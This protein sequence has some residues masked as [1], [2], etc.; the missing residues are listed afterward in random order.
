M[1][2][3]IISRVVNVVKVLAKAMND[4]SSL[5]IKPGFAFLMALALI[6][7]SFAGTSYA[8]PVTGGNGTGSGAG[9]GTMANTNTFVSMNYYTEVALVEYD[10]AGAGNTNLTVDLYISEVGFENNNWTLSTD[11]I[12]EQDNTTWNT[13]YSEFNLSVST[14]IVEETWYN[15]DATVYN[16]TD[17]EVGY[18]YMQICM[19]NGSVC[20][21]IDEAEEMFDEIDADG[22]GAINGTELINHENLMRSEDNQSPMNSTEE[23]ELLAEMAQYDIGW[24]STESNDTEDANDSMLEFNEFMSYYYDN[25]SIGDVEY[26]LTSDGFL[27]IEILY[28]GNYYGYAI[29]EIYSAGSLPGD[30]WTMVFNSSQ[31]SLYFF[32]IDLEGN[33]LTESVYYVYIH[34]YSDDGT[35]LSTTMGPIVNYDYD[36]M[37]FDMYDS[38]MSGN[39][40][41][42]E[43]IESLDNM[44]QEDG[45]PPM[46]NSSKDRFTNLFLTED[47]NGD[48]E[49]D[50][51]EFLSFMESLNNE[52]NYTE[53]E[54][55]MMMTDSDQ[56]GNITLSELLDSRISEDE[57]DVDRMTTF[58]TN[59]FN[60][61]DE[62]SNEMLNF[63][64]FE[65]FYVNLDNLMGDYCY[66]V[67]AGDA[68]TA[69]GTFE[70]EESGNQTDLMLGD[71]APSNG[72]FCEWTEMSSDALI[73]MLDTDGDGYLSLS[74]VSA[75]MSNENETADD[76]M[77]LG[78][79]FESADSD[80][81]GLL[82]NLEFGEFMMQ[83]HEEYFPTDAQIFGM[84]DTDGDGNLSLSEVSAEFSNENETAYDEMRLGWIFESADSDGSG[85]LDNLEFGEFMMQLH[86]EYFPTAVQIMEL[87]DANG[88]GSVSLTET[89]AFINEGSENDDDILSAVEEEYLGVLFTIHDTDGDGLMSASE[90]PDFYHS[91]FEK[92]DHDN[93]GDHEI[94][95][96]CYDVV[97]HVTIDTLDNQMDCEYA[98][99]MWTE[100]MD[101]NDGEHQNNETD[102]NETDS[103]DS[104]SGEDEVNFDS[105]DVWF[106][107]WNDGSMELV[108]VELGAITN[109]D[110]IQYLVMIADSQYGNN[111]SIVDQSELEMLIAH[112]SM[113][114]DVDGNDEGLTLD[115]NT[116][117]VVDFWV[118]IEGL[119]EGDD[120]VFV[121][122]GTVVE[123]PV[124]GTYADSTSHVFI[125]D[126]TGDE[127]GAGED[128][129]S[130]QEVC[131]N[132]VRVHNSESWNIATV[133]TTGDE[134]SFNYEETNDMWYAESDICDASG[135]ITF[136]LV[137]AEN[138]TM[139]AEEQED[140]TWE[141]EEMNLLPICDWFYD[142]TFANGTMISEQGV[143]EATGG[144]RII[145]L[146]DDAAYEIGVYCWDPEGGNMTVTLSSSLG[147]QTN[148]SMGYAWSWM[149]FA[150]PAGTGGNFTIDIS[151]TDGYHSESGNLT[152]IATGDGS[153]GDISDTE[154]ESEGIPGFTS[155]LGVLAFLGAAVLSGRR[156]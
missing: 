78:W 26:H 6:T 129:T 81:S 61:E 128:F 130:T 9:N 131:E 55:M 45:Q 27:E 49:L 102:S 138:S 111:D 4:M 83:L 50:L 25:I 122:L 100:N 141:D 65:S 140:W 85:L 118:E 35:L 153:A 18:G 58:Y 73:L 15:V 110:G 53:L 82:D 87:F 5:K 108:F 124:S 104:D 34:L 92:E 39:I 107:Q 95:M 43:F 76:E 17:Y 120:V 89:F 71:N 155:V 51:V 30:N 56:D 80:G 20:E 97:N 146:A 31:I 16:D 143:D 112:Y 10:D 38:D 40:S 93:D 117:E 70:D 132:T 145:T 88:D 123:F 106:E 125:V 154:A 14:T 96:G 52:G 29:V 37:M 105:V 135:T 75:E 68:I 72:T 42:D 127:N 136:D 94:D 126:R 8:D 149:S 99:Y 150:L 66:D 64:E 119:I 1:I 24:M 63:S 36:Q 22:D 121:R 69:E 23:S 47:T 144:D 139:P 147:N 77:R 21:E 12:S 134:M 133:S 46:D 115:G 148:T 62:D 33:N 74:E 59:L 91:F 13:H 86:E 3:N 7:T 44:S 60:F 79:I 113:F 152:V 116:G 98:G 19:Y 156:D 114:I 101:P 41:V 11:A 151:W 28:S 57:I 84:Y 67:M 54:M 90:F 137:K 103:G 109:A 48:E 142:V 2:L 32:E